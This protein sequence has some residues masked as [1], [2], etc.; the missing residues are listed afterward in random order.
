[1]FKFF[2]RSVL[3]IYVNTCTYITFTIRK[4][5]FKDQILATKWNDY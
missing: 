4:K 5:L 2:I 1:M 3:S